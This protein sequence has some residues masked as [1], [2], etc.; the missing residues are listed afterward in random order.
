MAIDKRSVIQALNRTRLAGTD[1][2]A[3]SM[4]I[5][6][7][8]L[9]REQEVQVLIADHVGGPEG[10]P[11]PDAWVESM[12]QAVASIPGVTGVAIERKPVGTPP[13]SLQTRAQHA[14]PT[15]DLGA[16]IVIAVA[17][18]KGGVGK[19]TVTANLASAMLAKGQR[20]GTVDA[21]I[22]G[23]SLPAM[24][25]STEQPGVTQDRRLIPAQARGIRLLSMD[26]FVRGNEPVIWRGPMLGKM[27]QEF[28]GSTEW[29]GTDVLL[30][31]LPP[32]TGDIALDVH[33]MLPQSME[34][35]VTTPDPLAARVAERAGRMAQHTG[36]RVLGVVE[37]M[38]YLL[39]PH[40]GEKQYPFGQGGGQSAADALGV[41]LLQQI[42]LGSP[43]IPGTGIFQPNTPA[44]EALAALADDLLRMATAPDP[45]GQ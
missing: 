30:L 23:F 17:S 44:E 38:S 1:K 24:L 7:D 35:I 19:S 2:T 20:A 16:T 22:Y 29:S 36:H 3:L 25:G 33:E 18:G 21:D 40:C 31:D 28:I 37:N 26:F 43:T 45:T 6:I 12:R 8:V 34:I 15:V 14:R 42:P 10:E 4:S 11:V 39:C 27:L 41:P 9:V 5:I 32:G 13:P